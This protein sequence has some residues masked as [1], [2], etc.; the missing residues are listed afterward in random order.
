MTNIC[1]A[2]GFAQLERISDIVTEKD[3]V[4]S[5]YKKALR[6]V[7][8][9]IHQEIGNVKHSYWT[10]TILAASEKEKNELRAY[11]AENGIETRPAFHPVHTMP[12]YIDKKPYPVAEDL[13]KRGINL[14]S[15]PDLSN[16]DIRFITSKISAYYNDRK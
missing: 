3:R 14:P 1:A 11:L 16:D 2:I 13:G 12:M 10:F 9:K 5:E 8:V 4:I 15:Y 7:P 6:N